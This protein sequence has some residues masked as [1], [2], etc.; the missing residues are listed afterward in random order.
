VVLD[1]DAFVMK[2]EQPTT[3]ARWHG[4]PARP[5]AVAVTVPA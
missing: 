3:G 2:G 5:V 1:T 4:N